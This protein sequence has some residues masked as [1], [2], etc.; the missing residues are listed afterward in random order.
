MLPI[1]KEYESSVCEI[2][3]MENELLATG[4]IS[5]I[6]PEHIQI[7]NTADAMTIIRYN[8]IVKVNIFN[9]KLGF[10]VIAGK[11]YISTLNFIR[12]VEVKTLL[13]YERRVFFRVNV[14]TDAVIYKEKHDETNAKEVLSG[15]DKDIERDEDRSLERIEVTIRNISLGGILISTDHK[16]DKGEKFMVDLKFLGDNATFN[17]IVRRI[18]NTKTEDINK[19][20]CEF[21]DY[22]EKQGD[23]LCRYIFDRQR[24]LIRKRRNS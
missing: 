7:S 18:E 21:F 22:S 2:K 23:L 13:D 1:S 24:E 6:T 5:E 3:S 15:E 9:G 17:C 16:F 10:K 4:Y 19:Y 12:I 14:H 20:G 8:T 11:V